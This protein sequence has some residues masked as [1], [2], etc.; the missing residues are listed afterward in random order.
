MDSTIPSLC[1]GYALDRCTPEKV[2]EVFNYVL[3]EEIVADVNTLDKT[4]FK[5]G[6]PF[7][8]FFINFKHTSEALT[9][10]VARIKEEEHVRIQY[11]ESWYWK[12]T[13]AKSK[14]PEDDKATNDKCVFR[15]ME[16]A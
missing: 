15:I 14:E 10:L 5:T 4:N 2:E 12:V 3:G 9:S 6:H 11:D 7:K 16:R 8:I 13:L 1:I